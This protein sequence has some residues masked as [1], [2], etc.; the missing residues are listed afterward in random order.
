MGRLDMLAH[1]RSRFRSE[2]R[3]LGERHLTSMDVH[4]AEFGAAVQHW[5]HLAGLSSALGS[6]AHLSRCCC[7]RSFSV[8]WCPSGRAS[9]RRRRARRSAPHRPRRTARRMSAPN[10]SARSS[11]P[12]CSRHRGSTDA[13]CRHRHGTRSPRAGRTCPTARC[14]RSSTS[15][16]LLARD[17]A[18]HAVVV[19]RDAADRRERRLAARPELQALLLALADADIDGAVLARDG[20]DLRDQVIHLRRGAIQLADQQ[21]LDVERIAGVQKSSAAWIAS[22]SIISMPPG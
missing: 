20:L 2:P 13:D 11:S 3:Y 6:K 22:S 8:N 15:A 16:E 4:P 5:E 21:R 10:A 14:M 9:R 18:V 1:G 7:L 19:G 12:G 17:R